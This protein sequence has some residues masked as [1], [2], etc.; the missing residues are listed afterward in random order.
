MKNVSKYLMM[1][2]VVALGFTACEDEIKRDPSPEFDGKKSIFFG[3]GKRL[4]SVCK[5]GPRMLF[6]SR[7]KG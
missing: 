4:P 2:A 5:E 6:R 7:R 3:D 1:L